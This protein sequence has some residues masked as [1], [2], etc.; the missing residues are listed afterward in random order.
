M[1]NVFNDMENHLVMTRHLENGL[2]MLPGQVKNRPGIADLPVVSVLALLDK[3]LEE[4]GR[5]L[6]A[7]PPGAG[8]TTLVPLG[9]MN[10]PWLKNKK[11]IM[12]EPRR[13]AARACAAHMAALLGETAGQRIG[14]QVRMER[15][16]G[17]KTQVEIVT[18]GILTRRLQSDPGL[19]GVGLVIFDE[20]H[21]R[22]IHGDLALALSLD[23]AEGFADDLRITVMSATMDIQALSD[24]LGNAPVISSK[25][26][27]WP[28]ETIYVDPHNQKGAFNARSRWAGILPACL[29]TVVKAVD[30]HDADILVFLPGAAAIRRLAEKLKEKF[31]QD[32]T[33][34]IIPLF[35]SLSFKDQN[36]AIEPAT[37]GNRKIVLA[38]PI[39]ETSLTIQGIRVVVDSG[40]V[41]QPE[42]S[43]GRG[44]TRLETRPVSKAS[45]DQRRGRAG[46][47]APGTCYRLWP[48]YIHQGLVPFNRPEILNADLAHLV[49]ELAL[50]GV[51]DPS[52]LKWLDMPSPRAVEA[53]KKLLVS[54][55]ALDHEGAITAHGR[56]MLTAGIHPRLAHMILRAKEMSHGF[57]GCCLC[58]VV[59]EKDI[60]GSPHGRRDPDIV[61]RLEIL[62]RLSQSQTHKRPLPHR[63][64][65][66]SILA[67]ARRLA[68]LFNIQ[69]RDLD[70]NAAGRLLAQAF[71]DRV[72]VRRSAG[73]LSFITAKGRGLF[74][75]TENTLSARDF[76]VAVEVDGQAKNARIFLAAALDRTDLEND[77]STELETQDAVDWDQGT[78]SVKAARQTLFGRIVVSQNPLPEP[79]PE[80]VKSAMI[81]GI[82]QNGL[83]TLEWQKKTMNF[84][85]RVIF[86]KNFAKAESNFAQLPDVGDKNLT[87]N[88]SD[89]L[90][91]FLS[92][93]NSTAGL[94]HLDLDAAIK[95]LF[96]WD[97]LK[98]VDRHAPT[99]IRVP[100]GSNIPIRYADKNGPLESAV[101]AVRIQEVFGMAAT[102]VIAAGQ[103]PLTLHLLSPASRP[104]QITT[105]L[106]HFW[107]HTYQ[108]VKKDL[109]GRYPKHY[110]PQDPHTAQAT[111][112]AKPRKHK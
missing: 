93:V 43:P 64:R 80:L 86:L 23:A 70:M 73:S 7:A 111:A 68:G 88:L 10:R 109:M 94:K 14:Y 38:T 102:P 82:K 67:Q 75:D 8:K 95:A 41:N 13:L 44:M 37:P 72:A 5:A 98:M 66:L 112:R 104:V 47:T 2:S 84:R 15:C 85:H 58:A 100:S 3:A 46:R 4:K 9:L 45:A 106:E 99:H 78:G 87:E 74:F 97:Q 61:L 101:L 25:G 18:E 63:E 81:R 52:E 27:I 48:Q 12:L 107:A 76:I 33:V 65:A 59:E 42:F 83:Q 35:G 28:V 22:H 71:P 103:A 89:W 91:P 90:G 6:L 40:L 31:K 57:L 29:N 56:E 36:A 24:L 79:D 55:G 11:I 32:P 108:E 26:K 62:D 105:D 50:W 92:G 69:G 49:L 20:F 53:A 96:T 60:A 16:I 17:P 110:W 54:L 39:A 30:R 77:F 34:N 51:R 1:A 19:E 21:E